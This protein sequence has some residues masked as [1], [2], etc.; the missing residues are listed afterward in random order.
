M[1]D[2]PSPSLTEP[3]NALSDDPRDEFGRT[4]A[5]WLSYGERELARETA[6]RL[7]TARFRAIARRKVT[8]RMVFWPRAWSGLVAWLGS[9]QRWIRI[10]SVAP[11]VALVAGLALIS[12][13]LDDRAARTEA[14]VD[15]QLLTDVL[16]PS[17][18]VDAGFREFLRTT[19]RRTA[20]HP[21]LPKPSPP[22]SSA[23][24][25]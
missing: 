19:Q 8:P 15:A 25:A 24:H 22:Q 2:R 13:E 3:L 9:S 23:Q 18:Y 16:P 5:A 20:A 11:F 7:Q 14:E 4:I 1:T 17:A 21:D 10:G 6:E 12:G